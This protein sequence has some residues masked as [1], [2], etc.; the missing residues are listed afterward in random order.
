MNTRTYSIVPLA[1]P[2]MTRRDKWSKRPCVMRYWEF[3]SECRSYN[4][5]IPDSSEITFILP[6]PQRWSEKKRAAMYGE[7]HRQKPD[8]DNLIK[9]LLDA[10]YDDDSAISEIHARK[11]WGEV[12][13]IIV[14]RP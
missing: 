11:V 5:E 2:R 6:M 12:G 1:K 13:R 8:I 4:V 3:K 7:P 14:R 9:A 10:V